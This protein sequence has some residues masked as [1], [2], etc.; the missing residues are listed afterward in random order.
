MMAVDRRKFIFFLVL[1]VLFC[2]VPVWSRPEDDEGYSGWFSKRDTDSSD[3]SLPPPPGT[4]PQKKLDKCSLESALAIDKAENIIYLDKTLVV[5]G[6]LLDCEDKILR[7]TV[8]VG[9]LVKIRNGGHVKNCNVQFI[10]K[11]NLQEGLAKIDGL[12][13]D[14]DS[15]E[16]SGTIQPTS[17]QIAK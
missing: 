4:L 14:S 7:S 5:D 17:W 8:D 2:V 16:F 1:S 6:C 9:S 11:K 12:E 3:S 13:I 10:K 15:E